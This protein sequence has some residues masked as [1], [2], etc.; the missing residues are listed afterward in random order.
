MEGAGSGREARFGTDEGP[1][2]I[3]LD[4]DEAA[5]PSELSE[6]LELSDSTRS[7]LCDDFRRNRRVVVPEGLLLRVCFT[8]ERSETS[9]HGSAVLLGLLLTRQRI[10]SVRRG[11]VPEIDELWDSLEGGSETAD[12]AWRILALLV[13]RIASRIEEN[14]ERIGDG[15]DDLEEAVFEDDDELPIEELGQLRRQLIR[16]RRY[17]TSLSRVLEETAQ[18]R[19][20]NLDAESVEELTTAVQA[21]LRQERTITFFLERANLLQDQ[22]QSHLTERTNE[23]TLRLGV[24][25]TVF[26][27]LGFLTGLLG[28]NVAGIPGTHDPWAFWLVCGLATVVALLGWFIVARIHR[29]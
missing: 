15:V 3:D 7:F 13:T 21:M 26:L 1:V 29:P 24:V 8:G 14:L 18:D 4:F 19:E 28:I 9:A 16:D 10:V 25:A 20:M 22:I 5:F 23:A 2:W 17:I 6:R 12:C 27:P 11:G